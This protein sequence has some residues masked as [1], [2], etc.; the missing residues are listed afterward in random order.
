VAKAGD[1][2]DGEQKPV[3]VLTNRMQVTQSVP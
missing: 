1:F 2:S 3:P